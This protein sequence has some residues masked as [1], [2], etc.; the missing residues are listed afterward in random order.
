ML[1][2]LWKDTVFPD[3]STARS[4]VPEMPEELR[5]LL[6]ELD[7]AGKRSGGLVAAAG[8]LPSGTTDTVRLTILSVL[9][10]GVGLPE[11][12]PQARFCLW[13]KSNGHYDQVR[14]NLQ[15]AGRDFDREL[16]NLYVSG[17]LMRA[18]LACDP[19]F[20]ACLPFE[21]RRAFNPAGGHGRQYSRLP[22]IGR[23]PTSTISIL[24]FQSRSAFF[25]ASR[26]RCRG[27][28]L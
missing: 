3:G 4:L 23:N 15:A 17:P 20:A 7:T 12:Y 24:R 10:K 8:S 6:R 9:L 5:A 27:T 2:H 21:R 11:L 19:G 25:R 14:A 28:S 26:Q 16:N 22:K 18:I 1:C 13:L